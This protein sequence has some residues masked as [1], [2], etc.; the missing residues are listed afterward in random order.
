MTK[1]WV[2]TGRDFDEGAESPL[3][4]ERPKR[5]RRLLD[6][7]LGRSRA[8]HPELEVRPGV[9][10]ARSVTVAPSS[11]QKPRPAAPDPKPVTPAERTASVVP[12]VGKHEAAP[13]SSPPADPGPAQRSV[14]P[15]AYIPSHADPV[16]F[17]AV[18]DARKAPTRAPDG[19]PTAPRPTKKPDQPANPVRRRRETTVRSGVAPEIVESPVLGSDPDVRIGRWPKGLDEAG[20]RRRAGYTQNERDDT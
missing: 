3:V 10:E 16:D 1:Q 5:S 17:P 18:V 11:P 4:F 7:V 9:G 2:P 15:A 12:T 20:L 8:P 19:R 6:R 13:P 14:A